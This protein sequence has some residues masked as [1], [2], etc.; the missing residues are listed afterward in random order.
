MSASTAPGEVGH[1]LPRE[2]IK[3]VS[4]CDRERRGELT[5]SQQPD[6]TLGEPNKMDSIVKREPDAA[7]ITTER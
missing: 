7:R 4:P 1:T 3:A 6:R 5:S 2:D